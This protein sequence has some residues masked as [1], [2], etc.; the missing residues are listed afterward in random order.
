MSLRSRLALIFGSLALV[1]SVLVSLAAFRSMSAELAS[2]TD[3]F[4]E[5]RA[6]DVSDGRREQPDNNRG[7][8][9][10]DQQRP[11]A[12]SFDPDAIVQTLD[13][14][15]DITASTGGTLPVTSGALD[16]ATARPDRSAPPKEEFESIT[17]D[18]ESYRMITQSVEGG[19]AV[20]VARSIE[21]TEQVLSDLVRRF[22]II[23]IV[24]AFLASAVGWWVAR[25]TTKPLRTLGEV[26]ADVAD[27]QDFSTRI[28]IDR[29]DEIGQ[30]ASSFAKM[31]A[32]LET[33]REQQHRLIH[34]A[35][36][37]LRTPLTSLSANV[38]LLERAGTLPPDDRA[39]LIAAVKAELGELNELFDELIELA[40]DRYDDLGVPTTPVD[41]DDVVRVTVERWERRIDRPILIDSSSAIVLGDEAM[42]ERAL[43]NLLS[44]ADKFSP[45]DEPIRIVAHGGSVCV[46]DRGPGIALDDR[47]RVFDRFY[48][49]DETRSMPGSGLGLAIVAQIVERHGGECWVDE[50]SGGGAEVGI[51][52]QLATASDS[53]SSQSR[54]SGANSGST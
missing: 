43:T 54:T 5:T 22:V 47:S 7:D 8:R 33:S 44:N 19:G 13:R 42:L 16:I 18:G 46:Q 53:S 10:Q 50:V 15:G 26:A 9:R 20:Q 35:S 6:S 48:R 25:R 17:L 52:L 28:D 34:D 27:T 40:T 11:T 38:A 3:D 4:L 23:T 32:A 31:L 36:H 24:V 49:S 21:E 45:M 2:A 1:V 14:S 30:L 39:D 12:L 37:E 51:R 41:L 29:S